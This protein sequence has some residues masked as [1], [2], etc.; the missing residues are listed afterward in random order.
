MIIVL[1]SCKTLETYIADTDA[2]Y[3]P[4]EI[5]I[6]DNALFSFDK[7]KTGMH[8][9]I[10]DKNFK[11]Q[12]LVMNGYYLVEDNQISNF[13][14]VPPKD[15]SGVYH[16]SV[17]GKYSFFKENT[18][19][20]QFDIV[21]ESAITV[22]SNGLSTG[23]S[24]KYIRIRDENGI[25]KSEI[26]P[27]APNSDIYIHLSDEEIGNVEI[28]KYESRSANQAANSQWKYYTGFIIRLNDEEYGILAFYPKLKLYK[29]IEFFG[30]MNEEI[31]DKILVY[32]FMAYE[33]YNR[34]DDVFA[35]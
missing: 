6:P 13:S 17:G 35:K 5:S 12:T 22:F 14:D 11:K 23:R 27:G 28:G 34:N 9:E 32:I 26:K 16:S 18:R 3:E 29:K 20:S 21:T 7:N 4:T 2:Y 30:D 15:S 1:V 31:E 33:S 8:P 10:F 25:V 19:L 24:Q